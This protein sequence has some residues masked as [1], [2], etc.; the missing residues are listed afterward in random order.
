MRFILA[1]YCAFMSAGM[2]ILSSSQP[3][4]AEG[5]LVGRLERL[6]DL[7][8][9]LGAAGY[10]VSDH[11]YEL[12]T[13]KGYRIWIKSTGAKEC[14][15]QAP[16]FFRNIWFRKIEVDK[17]EI[18]IDFIHELEF[19]REGAVELFFAPIKPGTYE[20]VCEGFEEKGM[21]GKIVVK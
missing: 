15:F 7:E 14:A 16:E 19:E 6:P 10:G 5:F 13:G 8:L 2:V 1:V 21:T 18:K 11:K 12:T 17:V 3:A 4:Q 20:W 9:G